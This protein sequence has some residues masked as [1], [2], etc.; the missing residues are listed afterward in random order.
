M[1]QRTLPIA[2]AL[3]AAT[4]S[5]A[6]L[7]QARDDVLTTKGCVTCHDAEKKKVG[8]PF[9]E[10][11]A[12]NKGKAAK[13]EASLKEAKGHPKVNATDAEIKAAVEAVLATK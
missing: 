11:A 12:K 8:P 7:T 6:T 2:L 1:L 13:R 3:A 9:K 5:T 4:I 10:I